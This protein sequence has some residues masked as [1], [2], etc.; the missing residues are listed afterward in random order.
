MGKWRVIPVTRPDPDKL[1]SSTAA[2]LHARKLVG[3]R[4][5][6]D[7]ARFQWLT[8]R[9]LSTVETMVAVAGATVV[10]TLLVAVCMV[11]LT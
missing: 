8:S 1:S 11:L 6:K 4:A 3:V 2:D 10:I 7:S 5:L 9:A